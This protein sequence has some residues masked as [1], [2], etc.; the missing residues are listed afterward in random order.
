M[1]MVHCLTLPRLPL[2]EAATSCPSAKREPMMALSPFAS[3]KRVTAFVIWSLVELKAEVMFLTMED[4]LANWPKVDAL[5]S[6]I[7]E[8]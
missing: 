3:L 8:A 2:M 7:L 1:S 4:W 5:N 6:L